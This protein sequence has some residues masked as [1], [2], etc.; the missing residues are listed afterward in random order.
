MAYDLLELDGRDVREEPLTWRREHL[1]QLV[2][3]ADLPMLVLSE[4]LPFT[5]WQEVVELREHA[6]ASSIEGLMLKRLDSTYEVGRRRGAWWKWKVDP[7]SIDA[8][9]TY[10]MQGHGRR[11]GLYTDHTFGL[12]Q[13]GELVTFAK[14]YS[15]LTDVEMKEVDAFVKKHTVQRF[16][17]VRQVEPELVFEIAFEGIGA[18]TRHK[19]GV[20]V[21]FPRIARWRK[22]KKPEDANSLDD[23]K[24]LIRP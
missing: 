2:S 10:S 18:S 22:D 3:T 4:A 1:E 16:V 20:A 15:G 5:T 7:L 17:P 19:S 14:A 21:R 6:R 12:W 9:L 13:D 24:A 11:A 8:V 23:L